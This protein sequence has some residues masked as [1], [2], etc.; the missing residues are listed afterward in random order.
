MNPLLITAA[1]VF[2]L[3]F[4]QIFSGSNSKHA[5]YKIERR[6]EN[7]EYLLYELAERNRISIGIVEK[8]D[9]PV[10]KK[11]RNDEELIRLIQQGKKIEAIKRVRQREGYGLK[12]A[13]DYVDQLDW[14]INHR[15]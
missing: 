10:I 1:A 6:L 15:S 3:V 5:I 4:Y 14:R 7:I 9:V 12:E 13:K 8:H 11:E 2:L